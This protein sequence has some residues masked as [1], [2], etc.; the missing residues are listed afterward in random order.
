MNSSPSDK[1]EG[2]SAQ[3]TGSLLP[4][5]SFSF[6]LWFNLIL[7]LLSWLASWFTNLSVK[8]VWLKLWMWMCANLRAWR[9]SLKCLNI[10]FYRVSLI[11][12]HKFGGFTVPVY[13]YTNRYSTWALLYL[14]SCVVCWLG[15]FATKNKASCLTRGVIL[16]CITL[17]TVP[18]CCLISTCINDNN[19]T[20]P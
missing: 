6:L 2:N 1:I 17:A 15:N 18:T 9:H 20:E 10:I 5:P 11:G 8:N 13:R 14:I 16:A 3:A 12:F 7:I 19:P 4:S